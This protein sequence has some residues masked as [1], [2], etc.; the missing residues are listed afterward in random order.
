MERNKNKTP[1]PFNSQEQKWED[2]MEKYQNEASELETFVEENQQNALKRIKHS[3]AYNYIILAIKED[4]PPDQL[5][6]YLER[7]KH[8][9][10]VEIRFYVGIS[11]IADV[12]PYHYNLSHPSTS[13]SLAESGWYL[14]KAEI[15]THSDNTTTNNQN[16]SKKFEAFLMVSVYSRVNNTDKI[17]EFNTKL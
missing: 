11:P 2:V 8:N 10:S 1:I 16:N 15:I 4:L 7:N 13:R 17:L 9:Q 6:T 14:Y 5:M 12:H 3:P